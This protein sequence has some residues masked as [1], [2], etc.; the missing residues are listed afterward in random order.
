MMFCLPG[1]L[2][3]TAWNP[4]SQ[5]VTVEE[6]QNRNKSLVADIEEAGYAYYSF[7]GEGDEEAPSGPA[8]DRKH[9]PQGEKWAEPGESTYPQIHVLAAQ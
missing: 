6:N 8:D 7:V 5:S 1:A 9:V 2:F 4:Y 3:I